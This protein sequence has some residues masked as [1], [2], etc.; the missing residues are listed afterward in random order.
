MKKDLP[1]IYANPLEKKIQNSQE[2]FYEELRMEK[3]TNSNEI[4]DV[5]KKLSRIFA[6]KDFVY[7]KE[8]RITTDKEVLI[9]HLVGKTESHVLTLDNMAIPIMNVI[10]VEVL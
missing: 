6:A 9:K 3:E 1:K 4:V 8:V 5:E 7:K 10:D 2:L